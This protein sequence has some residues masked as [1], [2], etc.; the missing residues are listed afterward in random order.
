MNSAR[1]KTLRKLDARLRAS[2]LEKPAL[3]AE[4][5]ELKSYS[6]IMKPS[7]SCWTI[8]TRGRESRSLHE[9]EKDS[10]GSTRN[11]STSSNQAQG[12][13]SFGSKMSKV[14]DAKVHKMQK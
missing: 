14:E 8:S 4:V 13:K 2:E 3:G 10:Q 6:L 7:S 5:E 11:L 12:P 1:T 9:R